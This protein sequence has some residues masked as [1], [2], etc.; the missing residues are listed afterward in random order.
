MMIMMMMV[1]MIIEHQRGDWLQAGRSGDR[2]P[3]GAM[4]SARVQTGPGAHLASNTM[5]TE[6]LS[7]AISGRCVTL[8]THPNLAP[9][10]KKE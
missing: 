1:M 3:A 9:R 6:S 8:N 7:P 2:I 10:L 5:G 4:V